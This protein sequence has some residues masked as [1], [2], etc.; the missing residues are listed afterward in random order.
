MATPSTS[1]GAGLVAGL[2]AAAAFATSGPFVK[3]LLAAGWTPGAALIARIGF[4]LVLLAGPAALALRGRLRAVAEEW[5]LVVAFGALGVAGCQAFYFAAVERLPVAV[6]L[7]VEYTSPVL[8]VGLAWIRTRRPPALA[9]LAGAAVS[10]TGLFLVL[11]VTGAGGPDPV[12]LAF[13]AGAAVCGAAYFL[14]SA[15]ESAVPPLA[16]AAGG[17]AVALVALAVLAASGLLP[18]VAP[19]VDVALGGATVSWV[20]PVVVV[21]VVASAVAYGIGV[22]AVSW[23]GERLASFVSL[24]EVL[25]AVVLAWFLLG[26]QP[27]A[28]QVAGAAL[29]VVGVVLVRLGHDGAPAAVADPAVGLDAAAVR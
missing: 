25:F 1:R 4:G 9:V 21:S 17:M 18:V 20:V 13:A 2:V 24:S 19:R 3:P 26:E 8:L 16:L 6:A 22:V 27:G 10:M 29:V 23:L 5:R 28:V 7:L 15:R 12:G 14:L 11:D